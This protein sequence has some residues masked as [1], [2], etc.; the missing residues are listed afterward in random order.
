MPLLRFLAFS[1]FLVIAVNAQANSKSQAQNFYRNFWYPTYKNTPLDYCSVDGKECGRIVATS[2][3]KIMGY[4]KASNDIEAYNVGLTHY[5]LTRQQCKG[6]GCNGFMLITCVGNFSQ[7]PA[8]RY[9]FRLERFVFPYF[10]HYRVDW[11]YVNGQKCGQRAAHSFC[12]RMGYMRTKGFKKQENVPATKALGNHK[13]CFGN[14][15][16]G[17][18]EITCYR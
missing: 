2:Y 17:F 18:S 15:C 13:L 3:C 12:R 9:H 8:E 16:S 7:K 11:C 5:L 4:E 14:Q 10:D 1:L 6:W